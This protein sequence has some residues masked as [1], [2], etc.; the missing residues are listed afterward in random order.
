[1]SVART[2]GTLL[3]S[4]TISR[5]DNEGGGGRE[6]NGL[7]ESLIRKDKLEFGFIVFLVSETSY[8]MTFLP[9]LVFV[10]FPSFEWCTY[11]FSNLFLI[12]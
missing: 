8:R 10:S 1:M 7:W 2:S 12:K 9:L 4:I 5:G 11:T 6:G 3:T